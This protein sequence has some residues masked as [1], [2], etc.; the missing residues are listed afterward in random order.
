MEAVGLGNPEIVRLLLDRGASH[1]LD[2]RDHHSLLAEAS[3]QGHV[4]VARLLIED[5]AALHAI[6]WDELTPLA[7]A[8]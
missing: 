5:G 6:G 1:F 7:W 8:K 2:W 3:K 4:E